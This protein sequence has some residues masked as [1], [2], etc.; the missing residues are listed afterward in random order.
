MKR[1]P[2]LGDH[3]TKISLVNG[4]YLEGPETF[5]CGHHRGVREPEFQ[6]AVLGDDLAAAIEILIQ[7]R[8]KR[9]GSAPKALQEIQL[10][11]DPKK[12]EEEVVDLSKNSDG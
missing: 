2:L 10:G 12:F 5:G 11:A 6:I 3:C 9:E 1:T 4:Q 7:E 8:F